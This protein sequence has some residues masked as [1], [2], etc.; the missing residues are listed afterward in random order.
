MDVTTFFTQLLQPAKDTG[1]VREPDEISDF[2]SAWRFVQVSS[3]SC[4]AVHHG[5]DQTR[6]PS[7][8]LMRDS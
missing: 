2:D 6:K 1:Q 4:E 8:N 5:A 3:P 7:N